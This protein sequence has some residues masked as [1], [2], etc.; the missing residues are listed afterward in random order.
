MNKPGEESIKDKEMIFQ[1]VEIKVPR[2]G[3]LTYAEGIPRLFEFLRSVDIECELVDGGL[4]I[5]YGPNIED[6]EA[7]FAEG[8]VTLFNMRVLIS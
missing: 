4:G 6:D 1:T 7:E 3:T 8:M 5:K 2:S